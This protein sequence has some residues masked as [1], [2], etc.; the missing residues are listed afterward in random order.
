MKK[1]LIF[2]V[3]VAVLGVGGWFAYQQYFLPTQAQ[4]QAPTYETV[5]VERGPIAST[6]NATGSIEPEAQVSL[7]FRSVGPVANVL[8]ANVDGEQQG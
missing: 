7:F 1:F 2:V 8:A 3:I 4:A 5:Q 6:V